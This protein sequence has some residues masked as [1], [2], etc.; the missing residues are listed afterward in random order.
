[1]N[2]LS[3]PMWTKVHLA[4]CDTFPAATPRPWR[5][6]LLQPSWWF[7]TFIMRDGGRDCAGTSR[8]LRVCG[9]W[10]IRY[11]SGAWERVA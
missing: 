5:Y 1:M 7:W 4:E 8:A 9:R 3:T 10:W 2:T 6:Y 11:P